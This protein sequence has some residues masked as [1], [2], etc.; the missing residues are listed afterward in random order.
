MESFFRMDPQLRFGGDLSAHR[1]ARV[2]PRTPVGA[3]QAVPARSASLPG[4]TV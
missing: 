4:T 1:P 3:P 2:L